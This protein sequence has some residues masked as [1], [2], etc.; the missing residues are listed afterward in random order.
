MATD[1]VIGYLLLRDA[2]NAAGHDAAGPQAARKLKVAAIFTAK[3]PSRV[4]AGHRFITTEKGALL[5]DYLDVIG[6]L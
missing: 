1:L 2:G 4:E 6:A 5:N 3:L